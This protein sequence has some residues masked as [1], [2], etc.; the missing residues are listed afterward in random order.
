M[1]A[2]KPRILYPQRLR[3]EKIEEKYGKFINMIKEVRIN[4]PLID[5][6][7][8]MPNYGKFL[9]EFVSNK[10]KLEEISAAFLNEECSAIIQKNSTKT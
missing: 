10:N 9:K 2:Y 4:V 7:A 1:K 5:V 6:L 8:G 3:K